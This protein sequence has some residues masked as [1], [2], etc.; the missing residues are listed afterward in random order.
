MHVL[1]AI[2]VFPK[3]LPN[4]NL[5]VPLWRLPYE[6]L[7]ITFFPNDIFNVKRPQLSEIKRLGP[8]TP[9]S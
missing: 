8:G 9:G 6:P 5:T 3:T 7:A 2:R 4:K 1:S